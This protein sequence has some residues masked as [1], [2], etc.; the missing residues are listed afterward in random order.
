MTIPL[1]SLD[2]NK[3]L[4]APSI[5]AA[6]FA[7]L[8]K[9]I[10]SVED[11]GADII[12]VDV[13]DGHFVPNI[14]LGPPVIKSIRKETELPF[15]V[16][17]MISDPLKYIKPFADAGSDNITFHLEASGDPNEI[18]S[19]IRNA[20]CSVGICLKPNTSADLIL[21]LL[22]KIDLVL[23]MTV[24]P[25]F[26]GQSFMADMMPK[27]KEIREKIES[28]NLPVHLEVDGGIDENTVKTAVEAGANML[29]AG[30]SV[31]RHPKGLKYAI[32]ALRKF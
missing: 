7:E 13:M 22:E 25:G 12:H 19:E 6:N 20:G 23:V 29:V 27:V 31:F 9:E 8:G 24:E 14:S 3:I 11:A 17:L 16:H 26:G 28:D 30:T 1:T 4:I 15:D 2:N 32:D 18:I 5:L 10:K 21:P